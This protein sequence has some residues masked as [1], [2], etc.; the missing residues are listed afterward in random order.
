MSSQSYFLNN[1]ASPGWMLA[2]RRFGFDGGVQRGNSGDGGFF[3]KVGRLDHRFLEKVVYCFEN[4]DQFEAKI[5]AAF[6]LTQVVCYLQHTHKYYLE[7]RLP[8]I[9][10]RIYHLITGPLK[11]EPIAGLL[12]HFYIGYRHELGNHIQQEESV[13][14]PAY[15]DLVH[16]L[17]ENEGKMTTVSTLQKFQV[18]AQQHEEPRFSLDSLIWVLEGFAPEE[19]DST[20]YGVLLTELRYLELDLKVHGLLEDKVL[21]PRAIRL[22]KMVVRQPQSFFSIN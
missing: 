15:L 13:I 12:K 1:D 20:L 5:F 21:F 2:M 16:D 4:P 11:G 7:N 6:P 14:F 19:A 22:A 17:E 8:G 18:A 10:Q 3:S 9:E